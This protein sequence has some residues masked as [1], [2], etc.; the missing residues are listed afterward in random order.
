MLLYQGI[1]LDDVY[2]NILKDLLEEGVDV[3]PRGMKTLEIPSPVT[4]ITAKPNQNMITIPERKALLSFYFGE[5]IWMLKG[6]NELE[7]VAH[8]LKGWRRFTD[9]GKTLNGAYGKRIFDWNGIN[10]FDEVYKKL[11]KDIHCRQAVIS[12]YNPEKDLRPTKDVPCNDFLQFYVRN[13]K[14]CCTVYQRSCDIISGLTYDMHMFGTFQMLMAGRLGLEVGNYTHIAN[15]LHLYERDFEMAST[16]VNAY[17]KNDYIT[18][19]N[20][21]SRN[22]YRLENYEEERKIII[23]TEEFFRIHALTMT[24]EEINIKLSKINNR[25]WKHALALILCFNLR[26]VKRYKE[27]EEFYCLL[28]PEVY[29]MVTKRWK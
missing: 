26:K 2:V 13:N 19:Y 7:H 8:Y 22:D 20:I 15:S 4:I 10:Q 11:K 25:A 1:R 29:E 21:F 6:S 9:D 16:I 18:E 24:K 14:L 3:S 28:S 27:A 12:I 23:E 17:S 5:F